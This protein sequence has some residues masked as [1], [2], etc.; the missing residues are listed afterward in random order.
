MP[1]INKKQE[2]R[3]NGIKTN[4]SNLT[5]NANALKVLDNSII[6]YFCEQIG[7]TQSAE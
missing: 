2:T 7:F 6:K 5:D 3:L 1:A 4:F